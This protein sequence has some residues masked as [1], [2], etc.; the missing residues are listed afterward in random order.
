MTNSDNW[1]IHNRQLCHEPLAAQQPMNVNTLSKQLVDTLSSYQSCVVAFSGGVDS[2]VVAKVAQLALGKCAI[3]VTGV[4]PAVAA[5]ELA[6]ARRVALEIGIEHVELPTAE[7]EREG[8]VANAPDR[9]FHCKQE[10][11]SVLSTF[12]TEQAFKTIA[13][14]TNTDDLGDYRPGLRAADE[15]QVRSPLVECGLNKEGVR[16]LAHYWN[17]DVWDKPAAPCLASRLAYGQQVTPERLRKIELAEEH[18]HGIGISECRVRF[19][20]G[21]MARIEVPVESLELLASPDVREP[22][23]SRLT[24]LGFRRV[25]VDLAGFRS[26][27]LNEGLPLLR[28]E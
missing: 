17:L 13:N 18:L 14:G 1:K 4:G 20:E 8:Y 7:I 11:Y 2:A 23:L 28:G 10:L 21:E 25:T 5:E 16:A 6:A 15:L 22:L 27:S 9:C 26:G 24:E 3:A 19:H 12:A